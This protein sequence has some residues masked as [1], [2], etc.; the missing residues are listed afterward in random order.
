MQTQMLQANCF[1]G[2]E[3]IKSAA[4]KFLTNSLHDPST[5]LSIIFNFQRVQRY[6]VIRDF[7][8][9]NFASNTYIATQTACGMRSGCSSLT[10]FKVRKSNG[11]FWTKQDFSKRFTLTTRMCRD[12]LL[13]FRSVLMYYF[14]LIVACPTYLC[15]K[16]STLAES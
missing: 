13:D 2:F 15:F 6:I 5:N 1:R 9:S 7:S 8:R 12:H 11:K 16:L 3:N 14:H 10:H 4:F